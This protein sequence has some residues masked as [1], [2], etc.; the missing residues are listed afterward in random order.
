MF[1]T[2]LKNIIH[3]RFQSNFSKFFDVHPWFFLYIMIH[4]IAFHYL[5]FFLQMYNGKDMGTWRQQYNA[6]IQQEGK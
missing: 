3:L 4:G 5:P 1:C 6:M 2:V